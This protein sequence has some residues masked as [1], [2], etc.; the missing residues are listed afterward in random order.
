M[1]QRSRRPAQRDPVARHR[2]RL[3][4]AS[5][6]EPLEHRRVASPFRPCLDLELEED[7]P[8]EQRL[9]LRTGAR[10]DLLD[11]RAAPTDHDLLLG[12]GLDENGRVDDLLGQLVDLDR[13]RVRNLVASELEGL[14]PDQLSDVQLDDQVTSLVGR[15]VERAFREQADE[16]VAELADAAAGSAAASRRPSRPPPPRARSRAWTCR[17]P[18]GPRGR[19]TRSLSRARGEPLRAPTPG[20]G[21]KT[22][23][24]ATT[25]KGEGARICDVTVPECD[26]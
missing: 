16:L 20:G 5:D 12:L 23:A 9:D 13:D 2:S 26:A 19:R 1:D 7:L 14:L 21:V 11:H 8:A 15:V 3:R 18:A 22:A 4:P 6:P 25:I 10:A 17:R 24:P